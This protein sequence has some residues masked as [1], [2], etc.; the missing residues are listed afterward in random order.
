MT[1]YDKRHFRSLCKLIA[2]PHAKMWVVDLLHCKSDARREH[3]PDSFFS[4][5]FSAVMRYAPA[6]L[7]EHEF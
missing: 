2:K 4:C 5:S 1:I 7:R 3:L 6:E